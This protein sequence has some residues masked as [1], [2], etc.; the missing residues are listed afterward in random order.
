MKKK[1][2]YFS[3]HCAMCGGRCCKVGGLY[4]TA[5]EYKKVS[6]EYKKGFK[7]HYSGYVTYSGKPCPFIEKDGCVLNE[8]RFLECKLY[9]LEVSEI[10]K[11]ILKSEC[12]H[13]KLF[14]NSAF[15][16]QGYKLFEEYKE[17][18]LFSEND[19]NGILNNT[20]WKI[21]QKKII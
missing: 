21:A 9:P 8:N 20:P 5:Q 1:D 3:Q 14:D 12:P 2:E 11:L 10:D 17:A 13:N 7:K 15:F 19:V 18:G 16:Q 4:I 6:D